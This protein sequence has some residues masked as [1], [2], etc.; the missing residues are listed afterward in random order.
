MVTAPPRIARWR[1][2]PSPVGA[3]I[4]MAAA[5]LAAGLAVTASADAGERPEVSEHLLIGMV[6]EQ[7]F[8]VTCED[9]AVSAEPIVSDALGILSFEVDHTG[10]PLPSTI[11]VRIPGPPRIDGEHACEAADSSAVLCWHTDRPATSQVEY[12]RTPAYGSLSPLH[13]DFVQDHEVEIAPLDSETM[14]H[15][16]VISVDVFGNSCVS[17]DHTLITLPPRPQVF[18]ITV[19]DL[20]TTFF[21]VAW[22]T[23]VPCGHFVE[24]GLDENYGN[25]TPFVPDLATEHEVTVDG[26]LPG[27]TYCFRVWSVDEHGLA[28]ASDGRMVGTVVP[29]LEILDPSVDAVSSRTITLSWTTNEP[30]DSQVEYGPDESYGSCTELDPELG[31]DHVV[32]VGGLDPGAT[33]HL[34]AVSTDAYGTVAASDDLVA[35]TFEFDVG[36]LIILEIAAVETTASTA[37]LSWSTT[38]QSFCRV[39]Y[40]ETPSCGISTPESVEPAT[41]HRV[42]LTELW[43]RTLYYFRIH[44]RDTFGQEAVSPAETFTTTDQD[45]PGGLTIIWVAMTEIGASEATVAWQTNIASTSTVEYGTPDSPWHSVSDDELVTAHVMA[46]SGLL[47]NTTYYYRVRSTDALGHEVVS[48][49]SSFQTPEST[50]FEPPAIPAGLVAQT[51]EDGIVLAWQPNGEDDLASYRIYRRAEGEAMLVELTDVD[52]GTTS[53]LDEDTR[54]GRL[55]DYAVAAIDLAGNESDACEPVR[56]AAGLDGAARVWVFPNPIRDG[57]TIRF[58]APV[59]SGTRGGERPLYTVTIYDAR[60]RVVGTIARGRMSS[61]VESVHWNGTDGDGWRVASG[62]YFCVISF[63]QHTVRTKLMVVR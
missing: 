45:A 31:K 55:Y 18:D 59:G 50:D 34:R 12:G 16:R 58:A 28:V 24:Y 22:S 54:A 10:D 49:E 35:T 41:D 7:A 53:Y 4:H 6:P 30:A 27:T 9:S 61:D 19:V 14:Y 33:Y 56:A 47:E 21:T 29:E 17:G 1:R 48:D 13:T 40:G 32:T 38:N 52:G 11:C 36:E 2:R 43:P 26:L 20:G 46:M 51:C 15:Y 39:E 23:S 60:G 5:M 42:T 62:T 37:T 3:C 25:E 57:S 44:A 63:P 8:Q